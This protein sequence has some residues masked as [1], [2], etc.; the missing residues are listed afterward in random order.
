MMPLWGC[1]AMVSRHGVRIWC[2]SLVSGHGVRTRCRAPFRTNPGFP[3]AG[4]DRS[5]VCETMDIYAPSFLAGFRQKRSGRSAGAVP[6]F[7]LGDGHRDRGWSVDAQG[8][9]CAGGGAGLSGRGHRTD[10][11]AAPQRAPA[12]PGD[13][14]AP[15]FSCLRARS[16]RLPRRYCGS[17]ANCPGCTVRPPGSRLRPRPGR[18]NRRP[19]SRRP[20]RRSGCTPKVRGSTPTRWVVLERRGADRRI[21]CRIWMS[22]RNSEGKGMAE[23]PTL[24]RIEARK[25]RSAGRNPA[26][27]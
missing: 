18:R 11:R 7:V 16:T 9:G 26:R 4:A 24:E 19:R 8:P 15:C 3:R 12:T 5:T 20:R 14:A 17:P 25:A 22:F 13:G 1:L 27:R 23:G 2:P 6:R 21:R 10:G